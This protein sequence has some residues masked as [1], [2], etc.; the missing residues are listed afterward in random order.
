MLQLHLLNFVLWEFVITT[1][2]LQLICS[3][4]FCVCKNELL[5]LSPGTMQSINQLINQS[6]NQSV[7]QSNGTS[8]FTFGHLPLEVPSANST[9]I[10][11]P[12]V[13]L[14]DVWTSGILWKLSINQSII[15]SNNQSIKPSGA[16]AASSTNSATTKSPCFVASSA[17][18]LCKSQH[19]KFGYFGGNFHKFKHPTVTSLC[20][21][22]NLYFSCWPMCFSFPP[23]DAL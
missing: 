20:L 21:S 10:V 3:D 22:T 17:A 9:A 1:Q 2:Q 8:G 15:Q 4:D 23:C 16:I 19:Q 12:L 5:Y 13:R 11:Y 18:S 14:V 6:I 7:N